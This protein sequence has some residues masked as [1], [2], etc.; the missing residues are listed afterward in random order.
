MFSNRDSGLNTKYIVVS[1][2]CELS[3]YGVDGSPGVVGRQNDG[4]GGTP[5]RVYP[6]CDKSLSMRLSNIC[7]NL[8][9]LHT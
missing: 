2:T 6:C 7:I 1:L 3:T 8:E 9:K 5:Y 4:G